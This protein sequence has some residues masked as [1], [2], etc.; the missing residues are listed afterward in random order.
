MYHFIRLFP[1][2]IVLNMT[3]NF[4]KIWGMTE[5]RP[6]SSNSQNSSYAILHDSNRSLSLMSDLSKKEIESD[7][8]N[9]SNS[10]VESKFFEKEPEDIPDEQITIDSAWNGSEKDFNHPFEPSIS[11][12]LQSE[13]SLHQEDC[14]PF[15]EWMKPEQ[16]EEQYIK[17]KL[18]DWLDWIC[19]CLGRK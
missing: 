19:C 18:L 1:I 13:D 11:I 9:L 6:N 15:L 17:N 5:D 16:N 12:E 4:L 10:F 2:V 14:R 8:P 7:L 3:F